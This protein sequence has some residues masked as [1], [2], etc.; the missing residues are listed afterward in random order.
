MPTILDG[1]PIGQFSRIG[2]NERVF[3]MPTSTMLQIFRDKV[4]RKD[5]ILANA[6]GIY[7]FL[8]LGRDGKARVAK[9]KAPKSMMQ[10][11]KNCLTWNPKG[12][13]YSTVNTITGVPV[14]VMAE[15]CPDDFW[16]DCLEY[17]F[18]GGNGVR[19]LLGTPEGRAMMGAV[20]DQI[21]L[22]LGD[23]FYNLASFGLHPLITHANTNTTWD[24]HSLTFDE[25]S[26]YYDQQINVGLKGH[27]TLIDESARDNH[28]V[29]ILSSEVSA[30][31]K[32][33]TGNILTVIQRA[34]DNSTLFMKNIM[35]RRRG[36]LRVVALASPS[37]YQA[38]DDKRTATYPT[39]PQEYTYNVTRRNG[40]V[41]PTDGIINW[42]GIPYVCMDEWEDFDN[43]TGTHTHRIVYT[44]TG[45][46]AVGYDVDGLD[47][48][49]GL[50][51]RVNQKLEAPYKGR[52][53]MD[54]NFKMATGIEDADLL[55]NISITTK[56]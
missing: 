49:G 13:T 56:P 29:G 48:Y 7:S 38:L 27:L 12:K 31:G 2:A 53:F 32:D 52:V 39:I 8:R 4:L 24:Q 40:D 34:L 20:L 3:E 21:N 42:K 35:K 51:L 15:Q 55:T 9:I 46:L 33:F 44:V 26:D 47:Q 11:R 43:T 45:N 14:E 1:G 19:D 16:G 50:G 17:I 22:S 6:L 41:E 54:T 25:W 28:N 5:D 23:S 36:D 10:A 37:L 18:G 30:D